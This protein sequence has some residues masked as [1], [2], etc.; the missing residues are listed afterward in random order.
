MH[1]EMEACIDM[2]YSYETIEDILRLCQEEKLTFD[3]VVLRNE[4]N[5]FERTEEDV[6]AEIDRRLDVFEESVKEGLAIDSHTPS[7]MSGK[8]AKQLEAH[9]PLLLGKLAYKVM[10]YS[11]AVNEANAKMSRIVACPTAG[12]CGILPGTLLALA[13]ERE[14]SRDALRKA[15]LIAAGIGAV[16]TERACVA[17]AVGGCQAEVGTAAAMTAGAVV[18][19]LGGNERQIAQAVALCF[20]NL[21]G[22]VCDPVAGLVEVPCVKRN[23]FY[24]VHAITAAEMALVGIKSQIPADEVIEAMNRIGRSLPAALRETSDGGLATT[25]TGKAIAEHV[26]NL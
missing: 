4:M 24:S 9:V 22:L 16:V 7:G 12:S 18:G 15:F 26:R 8:Q 17:G 20:K 23:G 1:A 10:T 14:L 13:E 3:Q 19:L 21:L 6:L 2:D 25:V 5:Q 11:I